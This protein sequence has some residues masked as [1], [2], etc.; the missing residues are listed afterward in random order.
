[1]KELSGDIQLKRHQQIWYLISNF[2]RGIYGYRTFL[3]TC[4][5]YKKLENINSNSPGRQYLDAFLEDQIT[6]LLEKKEI[7]VLDIGCGTG[8]MREVLE[9]IGFR[10]KY[11]GVDVV[12]E[13]KFSEISNNF[14]IIFIQSAIE[15]FEFDGEFDL[16]IS[17]TAFEH[18][19]D[20]KKVAK[21]SYRYAGENGVQ[22]HVMPS[23]FSLFV[24]LLHGFRQYTP[25]RI[26]RLFEE[27]VVIYRLGGFASFIVAFFMMT[28]PERLTGN[29]K[30]RSTNFYKKCMLFANKLDKF[31]PFCS[32]MYG[33][34]ISPQKEI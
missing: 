22:L 30:L 14:E 31:L 19:P 7:K 9:K 16:V 3:K 32:Q 1:M 26:K 24:Y 12:K 5:W 34:V 21:Q 27:R 8:Y 10:G 11:I 6:K 15:D 13:N 33:I 2:F 29:R 20:D 28:I 4:F 17:N 25:N 18:I 23:F